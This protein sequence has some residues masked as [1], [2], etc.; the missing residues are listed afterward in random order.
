MLI[1]PN[2]RRVRPK[3]ARRYLLLRLI[4]LWRKDSHSHVLMELQRERK[5]L[6]LFLAL[7]GNFNLKNFSEEL[8]GL[9][10]GVEN[11]KALRKKVSEFLRE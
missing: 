3:T 11:G 1:R 9:D 7:T 10:G 5:G 2:Y 4:L 6:P 8:R